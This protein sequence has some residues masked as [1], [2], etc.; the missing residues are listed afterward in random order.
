M[1]YYAAINSATGS[2]SRRSGLY[3]QSAT[4]ASQAFTTTRI[5]GIAGPRDPLRGYLPELAGVV[6]G[7][8]RRRAQ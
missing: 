5:T 6:K 7:R 8:Q 1:T 2:S 3:E 4:T